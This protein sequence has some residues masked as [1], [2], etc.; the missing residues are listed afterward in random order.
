MHRAW[1]GRFARKIG[2]TRFLKYPKSRGVWADGWLPGW[3]I[4]TTN[5]NTC[6]AIATMATPVEFAAPHGARLIARRR[7]A[8]GRIALDDHQRERSGHH[9]SPA[10]AAG[11]RRAKFR[12]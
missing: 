9:R 2:C 12:A 8:R 5:A 10:G 11:G 6:E 3:A 7:S 1:P 4:K